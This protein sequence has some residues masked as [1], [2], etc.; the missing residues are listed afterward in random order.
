MEHLIRRSGAPSPALE[1]E[2]AKGRRDELGG[3][4]Q[5]G[6]H[7]PFPLAPG[8]LSGLHQT[9]GNQAIAR[10]VRAGSPGAYAPALQR[11]MASTGGSGPE[12]EREAIPAETTAQPA[13]SSA[14]GGISRNPD[15]GAAIQRML[16]SYRKKSN[17]DMEPVRPKVSDLGDATPIF[18]EYATLLDDDTSA[19]VEGGQ[20]KD[21]GIASLVAVM[22]DHK[23]TDS[24]IQESFIK[25]IV[26]SG[27]WQLAPTAWLAELRKAINEE[28]PMPG[29]TDW[30]DKETL[31]Y[32]QLDMDDLL[33]K[34]LSEQIAFT[35]DTIGKIITSAAALPVEAWK[36]Y[37]AYKL[38]SDVKASFYPAA[39]SDSKEFKPYIQPFI[40]LI[41]DINAGKITKLEFSEK[42][43]APGNRGAEFQVEEPDALKTKY[44]D[45]AVVHTHYADDKTP[46]NYGH[47]KPYD[48]RYDKGYGYTKVNVDKLKAIDDSKKSYNQL[49]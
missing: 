42:Y 2:A 5:S 38:Y 21:A 6:L 32:C 43:G 20:G 48:R 10:M 26:E 31:E 28:T 13:H 30:S 25:G 3:A 19:L 22:K 1:Q 14:A 49:P 16:M 7:T 29:V 33:I 44:E 35:G 17:G 12:Q 23:A 47:T 34:W 45:I 9:I 36:K 11:K 37:L 15:G 46:P 40:E 39:S 8:G 27:E 4:A 24:E 41:S 18:K